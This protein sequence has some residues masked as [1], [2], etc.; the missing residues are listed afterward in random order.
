MPL[1]RTVSGAQYPERITTKS[2]CLMARVRIMEIPG[3]LA[4]KTSTYSRSRWI[5][6]VAGGV[7]WLIGFVSIFLIAPTNTGLGTWASYAL[8]QTG[9]NF[10]NFF[11][12][13]SWVGAALASGWL[14]LRSSAQFLV[15]ALC[16]YGVTSIFSLYPSAVV[17]NAVSHVVA[18]EDTFAYRDGVAGPLAFSGLVAL[19]AALI[20]AILTRRREPQ[21]SQSGIK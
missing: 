5:V 16:T 4:Q 1:A 15:C 10:G 21:N 19:A 11:A 14:C 13:V 9:S 18:I 7:P 8:F 6:L 3:D 20:L 12:L 2:S 17:S